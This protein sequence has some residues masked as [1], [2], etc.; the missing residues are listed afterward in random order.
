MINAK[1]LIFCP[2]ENEGLP[3]MLEEEVVK[4]CCKRIYSKI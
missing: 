2:N 4:I 3:K 1:N